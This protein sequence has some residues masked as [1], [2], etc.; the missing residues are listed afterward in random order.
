MK[1]KRFDQRNGF[2]LVEILVVMAVFA[3]LAVLAT[4]SLA[5]TFRGAK[6]SESTINVREN[7]SY[8]MSIIERHLYSA[9]NMV[10]ADCTVLSIEYEDE[11]ETNPN[12][13]FNCVDID[14]AGGDIGYIASGS[15]RLTSNEIDVT[16]CSFSCAEGIP[17]QVPPSV[18]LSLTAEDVGSSGIE[19]AQVS[20]ST[21]ML[22]RSY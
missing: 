11:F 17:G 22:L 10:V 2:S 18:V 20:I 7:L 19:G 13:T 15:G 12:P 3:V 8:A 16:S 9:K 6:K 14:G 4:Q 5:L 21:K 1:A